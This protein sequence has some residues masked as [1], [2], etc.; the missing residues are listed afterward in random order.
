MRGY[1]EKTH[2]PQ[3]QSWSSAPPS[4]RGF[5]TIPSAFSAYSAVNRLNGYPKTL[6]SLHFGNP[7]LHNKVLAFRHPNVGRCSNWVSC[8]MTR[9]GY[10]RLAVRLRTAG[11]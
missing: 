4:L 11:L 7:E 8:K 10:R 1:I 6:I 9:S 5:Q 2:S 3:H